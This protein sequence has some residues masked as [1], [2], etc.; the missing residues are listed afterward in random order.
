[1]STGSLDKMERYKAL[2]EYINTSHTIDSHRVTKFQFPQIPEPQSLSFSLSKSF[3]HAL[4]SKQK[5]SPFRKKATSSPDKRASENS[6]RPRMENSQRT[7]P[8]RSSSVTVA[9]TQETSLLAP[10]TK[11]LGL[12]TILRIQETYS[13]APRFQTGY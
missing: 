3:K 13:A 12:I 11:A 9:I 5:H 4:P 1:M 7:N 2:T 6:N 8:S 10:R